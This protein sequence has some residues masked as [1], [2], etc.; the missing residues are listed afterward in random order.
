MVFMNTQ[1]SLKLSE[2]MYLATRNIAELKG[3]NNIQEFIREA[4]REKLFENK[5]E[6]V[7]GKYTAIASE[8][9]LAK[10]WLSQEEDKAWAHLAKEI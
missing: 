9:A 2:K 6:V 1:I 7:G 10:N 4:L 3:Y 5:D 8:K